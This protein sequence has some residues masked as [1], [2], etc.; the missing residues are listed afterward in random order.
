MNET[1]FYKDNK[2]QDGFTTWCKNC[3]LEYQKKYYKNNT[4][5]QKKRFKE[6]HKNNK[7]HINQWCV[8]WRQKNK[9]YLQKYNKNYRQ[10]DHGKSKFKSYGQHKTHLINKE[11]W[12]ACKK[13]FDNSCACCGLPEK[14]HYVL[15]NNK[16]ILMDLHKDHLYHDGKNDLSNC[17]PLCNNCNIKKWKKTINQFYN[18]NNPNYNYERYYKIYLWIRFDYKKYISFKKK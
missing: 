13:Y 2:S 18:K 7:E 16:L 6:W 1:Y 14:E 15:R 4:E 5:E 12:I 11:E 17:I 9:K 8:E 3:R 10:S